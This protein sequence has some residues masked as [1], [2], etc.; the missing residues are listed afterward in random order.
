M[1]SPKAAPAAAA[2]ARRRDQGPSLCAGLAALFAT[3]VAIVGIYLARP[4]SV[5]VFSRVMAWQSLGAMVPVEVDGL[6]SGEAV[7]VVDDKPDATSAQELPP[8][9]FI[10]G[11]PTSSFDWKD[12]WPALCHKAG[13]RCIALDL[14][15]YGLSTKPDT[16]YSVAMHA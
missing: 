7:F 8:L 15:G 2:P 9:F 12:V 4:A 14:L 16:N 5:D 3:V 1:A 10:H 6:P 13:R 11:F